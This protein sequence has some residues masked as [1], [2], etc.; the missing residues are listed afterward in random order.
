MSAVPALL[1]DLKAISV[2]K[3]FKVVKDFKDFKDIK[4][5]KDFKAGEYEIVSP[6]KN[7]LGRYY[8]SISVRN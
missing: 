8:F 5:F 2:L 7:F 4:D 6:E 3:D 1:N